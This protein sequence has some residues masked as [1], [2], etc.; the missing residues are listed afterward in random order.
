MR[1]KQAGSVL[2]L[3]LLLI[4]VITESVLTILL[5]LHE[6]QSVITAFKIGMN[7]KII[8]DEALSLVERQSSVR[9]CTACEFRFRDHVYVYSI[10]PVVADIF[11]V[12][13]QEGVGLRIQTT[14]ANGKR[15]S[16]E[17]L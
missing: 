16:W 14:V 17:V 12:T 13:M 4:M 15:L 3:I 2:I 7:N 10:E 9:T 8:M 11:R 1:S 5:A 6:Q